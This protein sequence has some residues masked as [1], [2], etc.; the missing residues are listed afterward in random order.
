MLVWLFAWLLQ[1]ELD[2]AVKA[3]RVITPAH[4]LENGV[5]LIRDRQIVGVGS[6]LP[7]P[8]GTPRLEFPNGTVTPGFILLASGIGIEA[9]SVEGASRASRRADEWVRLSPKTLA[10]AHALGWTTAEIHPP[11]Q[12]GWS[13]GEAV[14]VQLL[15]DRSIVDVRLPARRNVVLAIDGSIGDLEAWLDFTAGLD[16]ELEDIAIQ[17]ESHW[18]ERVRRGEAALTLVTQKAGQPERLGRL[19]KRR[20]LAATLGVPAHLTSQRRDSSELPPWVLTSTQTLASGERPGDGLTGWCSEGRGLLDPRIELRRLAGDD[21]ALPIS[22]LTEDPAR[23]LGIS[24]RTGRI[25]VGLGADLVIY[26]GP[27]EL[28][29]TTLQVTIVGG[30]V[31]FRAPESKSLSR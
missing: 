24:D 4:V 26:D 21:E 15:P 12:P 23:L 18:A 22:R 29:S 11:S 8:A 19:L 28:A 13:V 2:L 9:E 6:N 10:A 1:P 7:I 17:G 20:D 16:R 14:V 31:F 30:A 27:L 25:E 3:A 5:V